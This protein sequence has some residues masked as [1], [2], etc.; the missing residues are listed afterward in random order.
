MKGHRGFSALLD[1]V[2]R[3]PG[4]IAIITVS[5]L[6]VA[7]VISRFILNHPLHFVE[8]YSGYLQAM[9]IFFP[10]GYVTKHANHLRIDIVI[11]HLPEGVRRFLEIVNLFIALGVSFFLTAGML[12]LAIKSF[13]TGRRAYSFTATLIWPIL[14]VL[15]LGLIMFFVQIIAKIIT[16]FTG[17]GPA[18][19]KM[20]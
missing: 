17:S 4:V 13:M 9:L 2:S 1:I 7:G 14:A 10:L 20:E 18:A 16:T 6:V 5:L 3:V 12:D 19:S 8:E 11:D 15:C